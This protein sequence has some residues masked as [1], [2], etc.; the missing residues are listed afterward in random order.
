[1]NKQKTLI[2]IL[3]ILCLLLLVTTGVFGY[4]YMKE[5]EDVPT[6]PVNPNNQEETLEG[7]DFELNLFKEGYLASKQDSVSNT[8]ISPLSVKIAMAM[9]TQ[10]ASE[11]TLTQLRE[12]LQLDENSKEYYQNMLDN[13]LDQDDIQLNI[14]N[15]VWSRKGL[16]FKPDFLSVLEK[17]FYADAKSLDFDNPSSVDVINSWVDDK[18]EGKISKI[19]DQIDPLEIMFLIN[20]IYFNADWSEKFEEEMTEKKDFTLVDGSKIKTDLMSMDSD[21]QY[22]ENDEFQA[23]EL[24]YGKDGRFVMRVYLPKERKSI[25]DFMNVLTREKLDQWSGDFSEKDGYLELPKFKTEYEKSLK[26]I[27]IKLGIVEAFDPNLANFSNI[28]DTEDVHIS[29]V[30]HKTY[31][32]VSEKGTEAAAVTIVGMMATSMPMEPEEKFEMIVDRPFFFTIDDTQFNEILFMGTIL[33]P[34]E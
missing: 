9:V 7:G 14:A 29:R 15:S 21:F 5:K 3:S 28:I 26:E 27:L 2:T 23:I 22:Q 30:K 25:D 12:V 20:A 13:L 18:T 33:N 8:V 31:I 24:P 11:S 6:P 34:Q 32:D 10:G 19:L 4:M 16:Q 17:Y 1:M